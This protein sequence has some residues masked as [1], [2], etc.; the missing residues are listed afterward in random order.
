MTCVARPR[1]M[2]IGDSCDRGKGGYMAKRGSPL[3]A[4]TN[5]LL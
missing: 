1:R 3:P 4:T 2:R 5:N